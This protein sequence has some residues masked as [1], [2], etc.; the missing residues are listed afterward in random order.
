MYLE[1]A[2]GDCISLVPNLHSVGQLFETTSEHKLGEIFSPDRLI[3]C[4]CLEGKM[5]LCLICIIRLKF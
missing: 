3:I 1:V 4:L 5:W 2:R